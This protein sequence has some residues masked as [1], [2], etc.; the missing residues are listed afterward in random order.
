MAGG[1]RAGDAA[2][3]TGIPIY[4]GEIL[5]EPMEHRLDLTA[6]RYLVAATDNDAYNALV[7]TSFAH[8]LGRSSVFQLQASAAGKG[9]PEDINVTLR[10][11][12]LIGSD[13]TFDELL[14]RVY[15]GWRFFATRIPEEAGEA[16]APPAEPAAAGAALPVLAIRATG[17]IAFNVPDTGFAPKPGDVL[18]TFAPKDW[19]PPAAAPAQEQP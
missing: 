19:A 8:E 14:R 11:R 2:R 1:D 7:C 12:R 5:S 15:A 18:I 17:E 16:P 6:I 4:F 13:A 9:D 3:R 10:G